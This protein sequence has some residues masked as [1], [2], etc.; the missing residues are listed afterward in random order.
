MQSTSFNE[1]QLLPGIQVEGEWQNDPLR[2]R[3]AILEFIATLPIRDSSKGGGEDRP[4]WSLEAFTEAI[5][6]KHPDF[7]R[8]AGDYDSW[9]LREELSREFLRGFEHWEEVDG[10]LLRYIICAPL[11]W[12]GILDLAAP[13]EDKTPAAFRF[14][15]WAA[16]LLE[17]K[18][19]RGFVSEEGA[20]IVR[21]DARIRVP[22]KA[23]RA[24]RYQVA[25]FC[26][27]ETER[28]G[29][30]D[31]TEYAYRLTPAS[32]ERARQQGLRINHLL[33][34][35]RKHASAVPPIL[36][37]ALERWEENG[38]E[39]RLEQV[40]VLRLRSPEL[41]QMLRSSRAARFLDE[42]L[43]ATAVIVKPGAWEKVLGVLAELGYLGDY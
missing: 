6:Q 29:Q 20:F 5:R 39:A 15:A 38:T 14:S 17:G 26:D 8:P 33:A 40:L 11:H 22:R 12:L 28:A 1:L 43:S 36:V 3:Q 35:L 34:L 2:A 42:P 24:V 21:S 16:D 27:W 25:R 23:P 13:A 37:K 32:L 41:L 4:Y 7:Q 9:Y 18:A 10:A 19:P 31:L 30:D